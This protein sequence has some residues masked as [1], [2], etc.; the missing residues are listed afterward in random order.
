[1]KVDDVTK[2]EI[3]ELFSFAGRDKM[4][5]VALKGALSQIRHRLCLQEQGYEIQENSSNNRG[6]PDFVV[7][8]RLLLE[9]KRAR[10]ELY[11]GGKFK[12]EI[13]KSRKSGNC[14]SNRLYDIAFCDVVAVDVS[15]HTG[16]KND[17][18][19]ISASSL[20]RHPDFP[21]KINHF[22]KQNKYWKAS[23]KEVISESR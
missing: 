9:H 19:Y 17:Y 12:L 18:R 23:L 3:E 5:G 2:E 8:G 22:Q 16:K 1:M 20:D 11:S 15:E 6:A 14:R 21:N 10:S 4:F 13:Q 7:D